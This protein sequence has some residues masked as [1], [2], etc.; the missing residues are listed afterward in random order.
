MYVHTRE[1]DIRPG[2]DGV[3]IKFYY[4][5]YYYYYYNNSFK[6]HDFRNISIRESCKK[7]F[8][9]LR[10]GVE[11]SLELFIKRDKPKATL[12]RTRLRL[13]LKVDNIVYRVGGVQ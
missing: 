5:Y 1:R 12:T 11:V 4:Y 3:K 6:M 9:K 7:A 2:F 8:L 13:I 10:T